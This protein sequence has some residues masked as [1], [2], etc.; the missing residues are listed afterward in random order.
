MMMRLI[1]LIFLFVLNGCFL[2][3]EGQDQSSVEVKLTENLVDGAPGGAILYLVNKD[4][5][6]QRSFILTENSINVQ[7]RQGAWDFALVTWN[8][9]GNFNGAMKC[10]LKKGVKL[11]SASESVTLNRSSATCA[12]SF[13]TPSQHVTTG[14]VNTLKLV[15]CLDASN[16]VPGTYC[17]GALRGFAGSYKIK[18]FTKS[19]PT[20]KTPAAFVAAMG[21][22]LSQ[23]G[24]SGVDS[25]ESACITAISSPDSVTPS[26]RTFP[27]SSP[28]LFVTASIE[29]FADGSCTNG[30]K[31]YFFPSGFGAPGGNANLLTGTTAKATAFNGSSYVYLAYYGVEIS[32]QNLGHAFLSDTNGVNKNIVLSNLTSSSIAIGSMSISSTPSGQMTVTP[33]LC[34]NTLNSNTDCTLVINFKPTV[35]GPI[36]G[37]LTIPING[38]NK[39]FQVYGV[40]VKDLFKT[41][42]QGLAGFT[43]LPSNKINSVFIEPTSGTKYVATDGGLA[44]KS[45]T[46]WTTKTTSNG[47]PS[48]IINTVFAYKPAS[49]IHLYVGTPNGLS[50]S[51]DGGSTFTNYLPGEFINDVFAETVPSG[52]V[53]QTKIYVGT[54]N[55]LKFSNNG[56]TNFTTQ[57]ISGGVFKVFVHTNGEI[58]VSNNSTLL[59]SYSV[60]SGP[61]GA[62]ALSATNYSFSYTILGALTTTTSA[63]V[64][65]ILMD[66][67]GDIY[68]L[69]SDTS[70]SAIS[71]LYLLNSSNQFEHKISLSS[72]AGAASVEYSEMAIDSSGNFLVAQK[73]GGGLNQVT[74]PTGAAGY[75]SAVVSLGS[76]STSLN[77]LSLVSNGSGNLV[78]VATSQQ[79]LEASTLSGP[80]PTSLT[81]TSSTSGGLAN[82]NVN[83]FGVS[84]SGSTNPT[85]N[86]PPPPKIVIG[87][88]AG[89][90]ATSNNWSSNFTSYQNQLITSVF[91]SPSDVYIGRKVGTSN[92]VEKSSMT[93]SALAANTFTVLN[94]SFSSTGFASAV[95]DI[96]VS[97]STIFVAT[98]G[99]GI[100]YKDLTTTSWN[101]LNMN[102]LS[103]LLSDKI[104]NIYVNSSGNIYVTYASETPSIDEQISKI[105]LG[106]TN[107]VNSYGGSS[108]GGTIQKFYVDPNGRVFVTTANGSIKRWAS[109]STLDSNTTPASIS[110]GTFA[111]APVINDIFV[112]PSSGTNNIYVATNMGLFISLDDGLTWSQKTVVQGLPTNNMKKVF[113]DSNFDIYIATTGPDNQ[114]TGGGFASTA[115]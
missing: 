99:S 64:S 43:S 5:N 115:Y 35:K 37:T 96:F 45:G 21:A 32:G 76:Y 105:T 91:V 25:L 33:G 81:W 107:S 18:L 71:G 8:A 114:T 103:G 12:D 102:N 62:I 29:A 51:L 2:D 73:N 6:I 93:P 100:Y 9:T 42:P 50:V 34:G 75:T 39:T 63:K 94:M 77:G 68:A 89:F 24:T 70:S 61:N 53:T 13:F 86:P 109:L 41:A 23:P 106:A 78:L 31:R 54:N 14:A 110:L 16:P 49:Q 55:A 36:N 56:G 15:N 98:L 80:I 57:T 7:L 27:F 17:N 1:L 59:D 46:T 48:N 30:K 20:L 69:V 74:P 52:S 19:S 3:Q 101:Q 111:T 11:A 85:L 66:G 47:L 95:S 87:T 22:Y 113:V 65:D 97:G 67:V 10:G 4:L 44:I 72:L 58:Y 92:F 28:N 60:T 90:T 26:L 79:L 88:H 83:S 40:G 112:K 104:K 84:E 38:V 108:V 82:N